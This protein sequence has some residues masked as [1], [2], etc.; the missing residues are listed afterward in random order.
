M[1]YLHYDEQSSHPGYVDM[2]FKEIHIA[3]YPHDERLP[4]YS[5]LDLFEAFIDGYRIESK[6]AEGP[7]E[8][9]IDFD[10]N[11]V[12]A[13]NRR[14]LKKWCKKFYSMHGDIDKVVEMYDAYDKEMELME[15]EALSDPY[16][17]SF[18]DSLHW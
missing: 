17:P 10:C 15:D 16:G 7:S 8:A 1:L 6:I 14:K 2:V 5:W 18:D 9:L 12:I 13:L 4:I 11:P 3:D